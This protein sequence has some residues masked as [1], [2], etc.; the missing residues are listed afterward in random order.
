MAFGFTNP[1]EGEHLRALAQ[2]MLARGLSPQ[3]TQGGWGGVGQGI[4]QL[5]QA[6]SGTLL[7]NRAGEQEKTAA[8]AQFEAFQKAGVDP[9]YLDLL[10]AMGPERGAEFGTKL[11]TTPENTD[12]VE[13]I[14]PAT[15]RK[16]YK[17]K[18]EAAGSIAG[19]AEPG[20]TR[21]RYS[22]GLLVQEEYDP[23]TGQWKEIGRGARWAPQQGP[24][25]QRLELDATVWD[26]TALDGKGAYVYSNQDSPL[27]GKVAKPGTAETGPSQS[28]YQQAYNYGLEY[29]KAHHLPD[30]EAYALKYAK[31]GSPEYELPDTGVRETPM[32]EDGTP[33]TEKLQIGVWYNTPQGV[34]KY[35]GNDQWDLAE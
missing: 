6:L 29:A 33:D 27:Y 7:M 4:G 15:G 26:Q 20:K 28:S 19:F 2:A 12:L 22:G 23:I 1:L 35:L 10:R 21:E 3:V 11:L 25:P 5:A 31:S 14:D 34:A 18:S 9:K 8:D 32:R 30:P 16:V 24:A 13:V 17:R